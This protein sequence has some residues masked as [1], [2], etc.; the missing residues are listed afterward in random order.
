M[1]NKKVYVS[2]HGRIIKDS[3]FMLE[4]NVRV[5]TNCSDSTVF[6]NPF[7]NLLIYKYLLKKNNKISD[8]K[9][10]IKIYNI[11]NDNII[12]GKYNIDKLLINIENKIFDE[13]N[14]SI[15]CA[16]KNLNKLENEIVM[17]DKT[18]IKIEKKNEK[19]YE[20]IIKKMKKTK[21]IKIY[22]KD[23]IKS[24]LKKENLK[25]LKI[26][27]KPSYDKINKYN[28]LYKKYSKQKIYMNYAFV[29]QYGLKKNRLNYYNSSFNP[30][31]FSGNLNNRI[32]KYIKNI[33]SKNLLDLNICPNIIISKEYDNNF[34]DFVAEFPINI[35]IRNKD[36]V[37]INKE[38]LEILI[39]KYIQTT[40]QKK[41]IDD[42]STLFYDNLCTLEK[43]MNHRIL[44]TLIMNFNKKYGKIYEI[45]LIEL[46]DKINSIEEELRY[47]MD[48]I[49]ETKK[50][51]DD[52]ESKYPNNI[53]IESNYNKIL[54][55]YNYENDESD[56][57]DK[58]NEKRKYIKDNY[59]KLNYIENK[60]KLQ[61]IINIK[62]INEKKII[63]VEEKINKMN[64]IYK[65]IEEDKYIFYVN[66]SKNE[67][68]Y[69]LDDWG[70]C[71]IKTPFGSILNEYIES[72]LKSND[73]ESKDVSKSD[74]IAKSDV[75][76]R[77]YDIRK[78]RYLD[79]KEC[80]KKH[81]K[82]YNYDK[83][84]N[85]L[86]FKLRDLLIYL[87]N[88][89]G[90]NENPNLKL[91]VD[92]SSLCLNEFLKPNKIYKASR[93]N[94]N[95]YFTELY[96]IDGKK[97][98]LRDYDNNVS[99]NEKVIEEKVKGRRIKKSCS[100]YRVAEGCPSHCDL[101]ADPKR[102][103]CVVKGRKKEYIR[104]DKL[105]ATKLVSNK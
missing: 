35:E 30:C 55:I 42:V 56:D 94:V 102:R 21:K 41:R 43:L 78:S 59:L 31:V 25:N 20:I 52:Y 77:Y 58:N 62:N 2:G 76:F 101:P 96:K 40:L 100:L 92:V 28:K 45:K 51:I 53:P 38:D 66:K 8:Y 49:E 15:E 19:K 93:L 63:D 7:S 11:Y 37:I 24:Y 16:K 60:I 99:N 104:K 39:N 90:L 71:N 47:I 26:F 67:I 12:K 23:T 10:I 98:T 69:P 13:I 6:I 64:E 83:K 79:V 74:Q 4:P 105:L 18:I 95:N 72:Y 75:L 91:D 54:S 46:Q 80:Y 84:G 14:Y 87:Y 97:M 1:E 68:F 44:I 32:R 22:I 70:D 65:K 85:E 34:R 89:Y 57:S 61:K 86:N 29:H 48:D 81:K 17:I 82:E 3:Y 33:V 103:M 5:Y 88:Y 50:Y 36:K 9:N 73:I 27:N